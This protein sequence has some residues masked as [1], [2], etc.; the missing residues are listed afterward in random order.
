MAIGSDPWPL[1]KGKE[2]DRPGACVADIRQK[3][4]S[5]TPGLLIQVS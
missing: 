3:S 2:N 4:D 5:A 1:L